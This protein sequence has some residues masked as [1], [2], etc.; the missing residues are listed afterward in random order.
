[1][2]NIVEVDCV[3]QV[4]SGGSRADECAPASTAMT[5]GSFQS[6]IGMDQSTDIDGFNVN[7]RLLGW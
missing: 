6:T 3:I 5:R 4:G 2:D 1:M 7:T